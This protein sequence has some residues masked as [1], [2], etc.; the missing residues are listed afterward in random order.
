MTLT[1]SVRLSK[2]GQ[3]VIPKELRD[4]VGMRE[5]DEILVVL[6]GGRLVLTSPREYA[7]ATRG[8]MKGAWGKTRR[9]VEA[10][11]ERE[12]ESWR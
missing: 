12:R 4:A 2:K 3:L 7:R 11:L 5:G 8:L 6:D 10:Y 9:E 1:K